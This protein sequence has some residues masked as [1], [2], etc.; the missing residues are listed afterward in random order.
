[1]IGSNCEPWHLFLR[2]CGLFNNLTDFLEISPD[3]MVLEVVVHS[4]DLRFS[5]S[6]V[7]V[8]EFFTFKCLSTLV[9]LGMRL[10]QTCDS[11]IICWTDF[12]GSAKDEL[13][14]AFRRHFSYLGVGVLVIPLAEDNFSLGG[15]FLL[16]EV[17]DWNNGNVFLDRNFPYSNDFIV[18]KAE[19][20]EHHSILL[21]SDFLTVRKFELHILR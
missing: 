8:K 16:D 3:E 17:A 9:L 6:V 20:F 21:V 14:G 2:K 5:S 12:I 15:Q 13:C 7:E 10:E 11:R 19:L 1:M 4:I 18:L